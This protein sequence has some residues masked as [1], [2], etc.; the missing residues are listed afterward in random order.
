MTVT[1]PT[2][3]WRHDGYVGLVGPGA[4]M[5]LDGRDVRPGHVVPVA[6][7]QRLAVGPTGHGCRAYLAV[8]GGLLT[9]EALGSPS[10]DVLSWTGPGPLV[11]GDELGVG[12]PAGPLGGHLVD[13]WAGGEPDGPR[14]LRVLPGPHLERLPAGTLEDLAAT[15]L[16]VD[17][18]SDRVGLRL[19]IPDRGA[20][21]HGHRGPGASG[22]VSQPMVTGAVQLPPDGDPI[23]LLPDHATLGGYPVAAV[24]ISADVAVLGRCRPGERVRLRPVS[25]AEAARALEDLERALAGA[26]RGPSPCVRPDPGSGQFGMAAAQVA[27]LLAHA[28]S[29]SRRA[30]SAER[31]PGIRRRGRGPTRRRR[32]RPAGRPASG[33]PPN[34]RWPRDDGRS[35]HEDPDAL[36][37]ALGRS[38]RRPVGANGSRG[39][40]TRVARRPS[41]LSRGPVSTRAQKP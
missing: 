13:G 38:G 26:V 23:V 36:G 9:T 12:P 28:V 33:P 2:L 35:R 18:T 32:T 1:G 21:D 30:A 41:G 7:G 20:A 3:R 11:P 22:L 34:R 27:A 31:R 17:A 8:R 19:R 24:V 16:V 29:G 10:T 4:R 5:T 40:I 15:E 37:E 39:T 6:A 14:V 25:P